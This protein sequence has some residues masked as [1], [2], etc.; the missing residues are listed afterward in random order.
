MARSATRPMPFEWWLRPVSRQRPRRRA[1][2]GGVEVGEPHALPRRARRCWASRCPSRSNRAARTRRRRARRTPRWARP[3]A[4]PARAGHAGVDSRQSARSPRR[5][6][7]APPRSL[8]P[9]ASTPS[10]SSSASENLTLFA[11][12]GRRRRESYGDARDRGIEAQDREARCGR[13][14]SRGPHPQAAQRRRRGARAGQGPRAGPAA[15]RFRR[16]TSS[17]TDGP[18]Q[19]RLRHLRPALDA[20]WR[21]S[22]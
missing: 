1:Q 5:T 16:L 20:R 12:H 6:R 14:G 17:A 13:E 7:R 21:A 9:S 2:R 19:L 18:L 10:A 22:L 3:R 11:E 15:F 4:A 8:Q